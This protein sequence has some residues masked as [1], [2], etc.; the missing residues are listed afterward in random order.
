M[1][2]HHFLFVLN[3]SVFPLSFRLLHIYSD[4]M[5][6]TLVIYNQSLDKGTQTEMSFVET[7]SLR[8]QL[9]VT[10]QNGT[11]V[12]LVAADELPST[13]SIRGVPRTLSPHDISGMTGVGTFNSRHRQYVI[14]GLNKWIETPVPEDRPQMGSSFTMPANGPLGSDLPWITNSMPMSSMLPKAYGIQEQP[15]SSSNTPFA[16]MVPATPDRSSAAAGS[17][18]PPFHNFDE[19]PISRAPGIKEYCSY[20][21]RH[22]ECDYAQQGCLYRHEMPLDRPTLEKLGLRD[23]PRWYREKHRLGSYLAGGNTMSGISTSNSTKPNFMERNWRTHPTEVLVEATNRN[24]GKEAELPTSSTSSLKEQATRNSNTTCALPAKQ[25]ASIL[26][27]VAPMS[28]R[29][30]STSKPV[31]STS[32]PTYHAIF[33]RPP[34]SLAASKKA[35]TSTTVPE[36]ETVSARQM[37]ET[38][39]MLDIYDQRDRERLS[40]KFQTLKPQEKGLTVP[41][42]T[43]STSTV[44]STSGRTGVEEMDTER[45]VMGKQSSPSAKPLSVPNSLSPCPKPAVIRSAPVMKKRPGKAKRRSYGGKETEGMEDRMTVERLVDHD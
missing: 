3:I 22:G 40:Q 18:F 37:R 16:N 1:Q 9:F 38:I 24:P 5:A 8:P 15:P 39:R 42:N 31:A 21:L 19:L 14:D 30:T 10:R 20:W 29:V 25:S 12:P 45:F 17:D 32:K 2:Y 28:K 34:P 33:S 41:F 27:P 7:E 4:S 43:P 11:M 26:N 36:D 44:S 35:E 6:R 13:L 23:I